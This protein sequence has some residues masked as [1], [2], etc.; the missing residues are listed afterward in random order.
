MKYARTL[1]LWIIL[2]LVVGIIGCSSGGSSS[3][4]STT[5]TTATTTNPLVGKWNPVGGGASLTF[6]D[7]GTGSMS[8][9][10]SISDWTLSSSNVLDMKL[11]GTP[12]KFQLTWTNDAKTTM[13]LHN[14]GPNSSETTNYTKG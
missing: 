3:G 8:D 2:I 4:G 12:E 9:G 6:N 14:I 1:F 5:T 10:H 11:N 13:S 7:G